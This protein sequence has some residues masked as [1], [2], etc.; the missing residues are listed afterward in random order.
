MRMSPFQVGH[1]AAQSS[2]RLGLAAIDTRSSSSRATVARSGKGSFDCRFGPKHT[3][4]PVNAYT[5]E[6]GG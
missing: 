2:S 6:R 1:C 5:S 3:A 4:Q